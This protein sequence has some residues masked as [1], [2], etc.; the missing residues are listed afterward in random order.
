MST[1]T[2][3]SWQAAWPPDVPELCWQKGGPVSL[4]RIPPPAVTGHETG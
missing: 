3:E 4:A 2:A 1:K